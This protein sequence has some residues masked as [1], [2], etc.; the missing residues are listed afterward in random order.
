MKSNLE[1]N[2]NSSTKCNSVHNKSQST[3]SSNIFYK[4]EYNNFKNVIFLNIGLGVLIILG[5]IIAFVITFDLNSIHGLP[6]AIYFV[7]LGL[8]TYQLIRKNKVYKATI[9]FGV[10][11]LLSCLIGLI[12][13]IHVCFRTE[14]HQQLS[15]Y[16]T[17][18]GEILL[19]I[20]LE[21]SCLIF[22]SN[23]LFKKITIHKFMNKLLKNDKYTKKMKVDD[24]ED[25]SSCMSLAST[26][27]TQIPTE[28]I[29]N[30]KLYS[31]NTSSVEKITSST[32]Q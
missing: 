5:Y 1:E 19:V 9:I 25:D 2:K 26:N 20:F 30:N 29:N 24:K 3:D 17:I 13:V 22:L 27:S 7:V 8:I 12:Y 28:I 18:S 16:F 14:S 31:S 6:E 4:F 10:S 11:I 15:K 32:I 23:T 21:S